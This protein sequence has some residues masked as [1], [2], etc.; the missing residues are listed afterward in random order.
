MEAHKK[1]K[2]PSTLHLIWLGGDIPEDYYENILKWK[3]LNSNFEI[4]IWV[5][6]LGGEKIRSLQ[7]HENIKAYDI[8]SFKN[9]LKNFDLIEKELSHSNPNYSAA[10]DIL[11]IDIIAA[12]GGYYVDLGLTPELSILQA[13]P[14]AESDFYCPLDR[15]NYY[16]E[17]Q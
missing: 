1:H 14:D 12:F 10:S 15:V 4:F 5:N 8:A 2:I 7:D 11:R 16:G 17:I 9:L 6:D 13:I 3:Q